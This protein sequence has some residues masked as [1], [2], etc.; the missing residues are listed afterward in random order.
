MKAPRVIS[1]GTTPAV[2]EVPVNVENMTC[3]IR[4]KPSLAIAYTLTLASA[5]AAPLELQQREKLRFLNALMN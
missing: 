1:S 2:E 5:I 3:A 4:G